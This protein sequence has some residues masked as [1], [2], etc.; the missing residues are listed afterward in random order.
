M[1]NFN[2]TPW[3]LPTGNNL[4]FGDSVPTLATDGSFTAGDFLWITNPAAGQSTLYK[5][6]VS[7]SP[8]TWI[9]DG[10]NGAL[11]N[12]SVVLG[13]ESLLPQQKVV[14]FDLAAN[15][16]LGTQTFFIAD[17]P[18]VVTGVRYVA[19]TAGTVAGAVVNVS[20]ETGT[21]APGTGVS[22]QTGT[23]D[24][25]TTANTTLTG[26]LAA[27]LSNLALAKGD[28]LSVLFG[29]TLT[30]LAGVVVS[31]T[32]S[33]ANRSETAVY[34]CNINADIK[35]Q[36]FLVAN[37]DLIITGVQAI[38]KTPFVAAATLDVTH[39]TGTTAA[40]GGTS[41]LSAAM[42]AD[43][44]AN[45]VIAPALAAS[46]ATLTLNAG[47]RLAVKF[48]A[49]TTGVG[50]CVLVSFKPIYQRTEIAWQLAL[51]AQEQVAQ[52]F[53]IADRDYLVA[54]A[55]CVFDVAAGGA[56]K[57][58][59]T[60]DKGTTAPGGGNVVQTDNANAGFDLNA[61]ARTVQFMTPA[62][63]HLRLLSAGDRLGLSPTGA[64]QSTSLVCVTVSLE[65]K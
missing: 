51:N 6:T 52:C 3:L 17:Q 35:T 60:I 65:P 62:V 27:T 39:D 4:W 9:S 50:V 11:P 61:T 36:T 55:S 19:K 16:S 2:P 40:G 1:P 64:A 53:F 28:R 47:D 29:G 59:V 20:H 8:G 34:F 31:V 25:T 12:G 58:A 18:Y 22:V 14:T 43:G 56:S 45:T 24:C 54:D 23:F 5:C 21:Q 37:R 49:T 63:Q 32:L 57:L 42:A 15:G 44:T 41:I 30:T 33:P 46:A 13:S 7:G 10:V 48:S 26:T 38:Y